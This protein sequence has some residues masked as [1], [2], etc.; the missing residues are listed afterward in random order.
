[1]DGLSLTEDNLELR[2]GWQQAEPVQ[3]LTEFEWPT[4]RL[5]HFAGDGKNEEGAVHKS[6]QQ[7]GGV[8]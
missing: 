3:S 6:K 2:R 1:M 4:S 7:A 8:T 5:N